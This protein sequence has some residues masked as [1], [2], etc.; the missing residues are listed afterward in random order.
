MFE[1]CCGARG[2]SHRAGDPCRAA[3]GVPLCE[4]WL[5]ERGEWQR[6]FHGKRRE[7]TSAIGRSSIPQWENMCF[8]S[9]GIGNQEDLHSDGCPKMSQTVHIPYVPITV[10]FRRTVVSV[11]YV[12]ITVLFRTTVVNILHVLITVIFRTTVV[13]LPYVPIT[14]LFRTTAV[15]IRYVLITWIIITF[16]I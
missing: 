5:E 6:S 11:R 4:A 10:L 2:L 15:Y 16:K 14:V 8:S 3:L 12:P 13:H 1:V 7:I 9:P